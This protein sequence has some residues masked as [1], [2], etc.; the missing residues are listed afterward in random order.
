MAQAQKY[1]VKDIRRGVL[2]SGVEVVHV[3]DYEATAKLAR[4]AVEALEAVRQWWIR[5][6][7]GGFPLNSIAAVLARAKET[8]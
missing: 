3:A 1:R 7:C 4:E 8:L 6:D 2:D 5:D